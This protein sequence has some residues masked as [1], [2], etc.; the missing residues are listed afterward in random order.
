[1]RIC[2]QYL[3]IY[4]IC[5]IV[6]LFT[7]VEI[8]AKPDEEFSLMNARICV[9]LG[10]HLDLLCSPS[11]DTANMHINVYTCL[12]RFYSN[13]LISDEGVFIGEKQFIRHWEITMHS[14]S[15][16][17]SNPSESS[18]LL[19]ITERLRYIFIIFGKWR[20]SH[21]QREMTIC[22]SSGNDSLL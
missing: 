5:F 4:N 2:R 9:V 1:M 12:I 13:R 15:V 20:F 3:F 10:L 16:E 14:S 8:F 22:S 17:N 6:G 11:F 21:Y 7:D 18:N 19:F